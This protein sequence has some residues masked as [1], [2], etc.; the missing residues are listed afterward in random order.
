VE[1]ISGAE[2]ILEALVVSQG[3]LYLSRFVRLSGQSTYGHRSPKNLARQLDRKSVKA[4]GLGR[5]SSIVWAFSFDGT[6]AS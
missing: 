4:G 5:F 1:L 2:K 6:R 3:A